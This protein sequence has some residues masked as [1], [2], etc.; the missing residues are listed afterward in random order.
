MRS[1]RLPSWL[2]VVV[3]G[4]TVAAASAC[5]GS[6]PPEGPAPAPQTGDDPPDRVGRLSYIQG[7]VSFL[8]AG[9]DSWSVAEPN[10]PV[11]TGDRLWA[12][13]SAR[14]EVDVGSTTLRAAGLTEVDI[15]RLT[16]HWVQVR[17]PQGTLN[18]RLRVLAPDK[19]YEIDSP[20]A[21]VSLAGAGEYRVDVSS[22]ASTT[23]I[24][25]WS[26]RAEVTAAGSSFPV[27]AGQVATIR[28]DSTLTYDLTNT[29]QP[30]DFDRWARERDARAD[31][32]GAA[33]RY[34]S[35]DTPGVEDLDAYGQ[36]D[37]DAD[38]GPVWYPT[39][40][41]VGWA[42]YRQ[43]HWVWIG[44]WGWTWVDEAPWGF[45]PYHYGRWAF[46]R[47]R[48]GWCPGRTIVQPVFAPALV[49]FVG[50]PTWRPRPEF[51]P[52]GGVAWFPLAPG[53]PYYPPYT[54]TV[55]YRRRINLTH[56]TNIVIADR[57][58]PA[59]GARYRNRDVSGG[60]TA[61][62]VGVF[63]G[64]QPVRRS[65]VTV[66]ASDLARARV[67]GPGAPVVPT[68]ASLG[69]PARRAPAPPSRLATRGSVATHAPPPAP[70][71][72][73]A[74][75]GRLEANGGR[76]LTRAELS[77]MR[78][79]APAARVPP[80]PTRSAVTPASSGRT[81]TPARPRLPVT[82]EPAAQVFA[83]RGPAPAPT[84][85]APAA[86]PPAARAPA[87]TAPAQRA[88]VQPPQPTSLDRSYQAA[89]ATEEA[90]HREEFAKPPAGESSSALSQR[91]ETEHQQLD[92]QYQRA[93]GAGKSAMP[94]QPAPRTPKPAEKAPAKAPTRERQKQ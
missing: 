3:I 52:G 86:R 24:T 79:T 45:A 46:V 22:D 68:A 41:E 61:V 92:Q 89:R 76:P 5:A 75:Q 80:A 81:L 9:A 25:V 94:A 38:Y 28:G 69:V 65:V 56:I 7:P 20:N 26:G 77:A 55:E 6:T 42:P 64:A 49:I 91:Q 40:A 15:V 35:E 37:A 66:A 14:L 34:V 12:D 48:W 43:G 10:R 83:P 54:T 33:L 39:V 88:P 72:F 59:A 13:S 74:Q 58:A 71:P 47:G 36:W 4:Y 93:R 8:A 67:A 18:Q 19:D 73:T 78:P 27:E 85:P 16:D 90:R 87:P 23:T 30:D 11:T 84:A 32:A 70:V 21:A 50:G 62:P 82:P 31:Q 60:V 53:E 44:R 1:A 29:G 63:A 2:A 57:T 17:I 51:G